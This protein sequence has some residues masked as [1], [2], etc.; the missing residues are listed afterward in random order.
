VAIKNISD[1]KNHPVR[2]KDDES[3]TSLDSTSSYPV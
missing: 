1:R 2:R 3:E